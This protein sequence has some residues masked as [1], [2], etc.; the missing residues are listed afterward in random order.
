MAAGTG[1][2]PGPGLA[3]VFCSG[4]EEA[5]VLIPADLCASIDEKMGYLYDGRLPAH[6]KFIFV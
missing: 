5:S 6:P 1:V 3:A 4:G 2:S